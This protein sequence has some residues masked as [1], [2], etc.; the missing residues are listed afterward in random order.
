MGPLVNV[1]EACAVL[2][3]L[4]APLLKRFERGAVTPRQLRYL[5]EGGVLRPL[6]TSAGDGRL[7]AAVEVAMVRLW[8]Q[9]QGV[10]TVPDYAARTAL[11]YLG[12]QIR[13]ELERR[14]TDAVLVM[15]GLRGQLLPLSK[16]K[17][18]RS[19]ASCWIPL[20][21]VRRDV[22]QRLGAVREAAPFI[23]TGRRIERGSTLATEVLSVV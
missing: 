18:L 5:E 15:R 11:A 1:S 14:S 21:Q 22:A 3:S 23:R 2:S 9:I 8:L 13:R 12:E 6:R 7:Y 17:T 19:D 20:E 16:A 10:G 4:E